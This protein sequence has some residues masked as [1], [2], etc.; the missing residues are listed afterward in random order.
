MM[1][2]KKIKS[3]KCDA[4]A[5]GQA[6]I[7]GVMM[8]Q[9]EKIA[10]AVRR[11][12]GEIVFKEQ[13]YQPLSKKNKFVGFPFVRG[14]FSLVEMMIVGTSHLFFSADIAIADE[15]EKLSKKHKKQPS[16]KNNQR[17]DITFSLL[18]SVSFAIILFVVLPAMMFTFLK[19]MISQTIVLNLLEGF[20]RFSI[21]LIFLL[22]SLLSKD[23][24]RVF[25]YHGAEHKT[26]LAWEDGAELTAKSVRSYSRFHPR[27]GTSF[28]LVVMIVSVLAFSLL[29]RPDLLHRILYKLLLFPFVAGISYEIIRL[30][31]RFRRQ[32]WAKVLM[33]PGL[34]L[35]RITTKEP[36]DQQLEVAIL[37]MQKVV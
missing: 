30:T 36:D 3:R 23:M 19:N 7:E 22:L 14:V 24:R 37:A 27:C 11:K 2:E 32:L 16:K 21:L 31:A 34:L 25:M 35:Q 17:L 28:I 1:I 20:T 12:N 33:W 13:I 6:V 29:G 9:G 15:E 10:T 5:G 4:V 8:R 18:L 26:V